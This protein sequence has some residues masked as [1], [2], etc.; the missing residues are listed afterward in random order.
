M[1]FSP[2]FD[3]YQS[4]YYVIWPYFRGGKQKYIQMPKVWRR[5]ICKGQNLY[6]SKWW[7]LIRFIR[8]GELE[9]HVLAP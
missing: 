8:T 3:P 2:F 4:Y 9:Q 5:G 6:K 1:Q 7:I